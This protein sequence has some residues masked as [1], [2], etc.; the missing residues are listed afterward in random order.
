MHLW[1]WFVFRETPA[2][3]TCHLVRC[4]NTLTLVR[5]RTGRH[6]HP[7]SLGVE[8]RSII[9]S[10]DAMARAQFAANQS[11]RGGK[12][13][14]RSS[15]LDFRL[16]RSRK[17]LAPQKRRINSPKPSSTA[18]RFT[19]LAG[20]L[21]LLKVKIL[22]SIVSIRM[23]LFVFVCIYTMYYKWS[24]PSNALAIL[25]P[26][27]VIKKASYFS[28]GQ[29]PLETQQVWKDFWISITFSNVV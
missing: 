1:S 24:Y 5:Y 17:E 14:E 28:F 7:S 9:P 25:T 26:T 20:E 29:S 3:I 11:L 27:L 19:D 16:T 6:S 21:G 13:L 2:W 4:S 18:S 22:S 23:G 10:Q 12:A 15:R 8:V